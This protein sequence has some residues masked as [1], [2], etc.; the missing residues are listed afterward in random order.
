MCVLYCLLLA[1][2]LPGSGFIAYERWRQNKGRFSGW[3]TALEQ[4]NTGKTDRKQNNE[5]C[6]G[7]TC[8]SG[9]KPKKR[10]QRIFE[11]FYGSRTF[12]CLECHLHVDIPVVGNKR[13]RVR[14]KSLA[15]VFVQIQVETDDCS[16]RFHNN[17]AVLINF[18]K[19]FSSGQ[20][21]SGCIALKWI[22]GE[23]FAHECPCST[24]LMHKA[25]KQQWL[26]RKRDVVILC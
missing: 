3:S 2:S 1:E 19:S 6:L 21:L 18:L 13:L 12:A 24:V 8:L 5:Q 17:N 23:I 15:N 14:R 11:Q 22:G 9:R 10:I 26:F 25:K 16:T 4:T 7:C 20:S